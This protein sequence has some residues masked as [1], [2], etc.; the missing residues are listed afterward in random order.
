MTTNDRDHAI[1]RLGTGSDRDAHVLLRGG[2]IYQGAGTAAGAVGAPRFADAL[3][4]RDG[5]VRAVG[6]WSQLKSLAGRHTV[7]IDL[8]GRTVVPGLIDSHLHLVRA[9][10]T[11]TDEAFW[12]ETPSLE[13]GLRLLEDQAR[14]RPAGTWL[15]VVGGWH[16]GQFAERRGPTS[17]ELT[18]RFPNHPVY[19]QLLYEEALL[20]DA[21]LKAA[22]IGHGVPD[23]PSGAFDRDPQTG[24]PTGTVRGVGAFLHCLAC[25]S[26]PSHADK[27]RGT[28]EL[29]AAL[30]AWGVTGAI[31][32]GGLGVTPELYEPLFALW[33]DGKMTVRTR[34]YLGPR[35]RGAEREELT[36]WLRH[37][38]P[39]FGDGWL[40]HVG[41]GEITVFG[42]HDL[43]GLTDFAID[44]A[45]QHELDVICRQIAARGWPLH[46]H[47]V[48]DSTVTAVLDVWERIDREVPLAGLR[49]SLAHAEPISAGNLAR[50]AALG[51]GIAVQD[52]MVY[53]A[54]DSAAVWGDDVVRDAPPVRDILELGVPLGAGTD[55]TRVAS[56]NPWVALWWLVSGNTFD[57]GPR[58]SERHRLTRSEA[59]NAYTTGSAWFSFEETTRGRLEPGMRADLAVLTDDYF[60]VSTDDIRA[61]ASDLTMVDGRVVHAA[62]SF[63]GL[64]DHE[65]RL[66]SGRV[67]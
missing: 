52:R 20:N 66:F 33:R 61:L 21:A 32:A 55:S 36:G 56:P 57:D 44:D 45:S 34:L 67:Q 43:E 13:Q 25:M 42:C 29:M 15:R 48:L 59:L 17:A 39:G 51:C 58:R 14:Q 50:V 47:A 64:T 46:L 26:E 18:R 16:P 65:P 5:R 8:E 11:W 37:T 62:G 1:A 2:A 22:G 41:I 27:V 53:R 60:S 38:R 12:Y 10:L 19:I 28:A 54:T 35:T 49:W 7:T 6:P 23:P 3:A 9:G 30:N 31:D 24:V 4:I 63:T 40:R